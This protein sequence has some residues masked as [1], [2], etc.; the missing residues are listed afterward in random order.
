MLGWEEGRKYQVAGEVRTRLVKTSCDAP[1]VS[2]WIEG[3]QA[4]LATEYL[5]LYI[6]VYRTMLEMKSPPAILAELAKRD[7][8]TADIDSID[9]ALREIE[10]SGA[11]PDGGGPWSHYIERTAQAVRRFVPLLDVQEA[12]SEVA[13]LVPRA[14]LISELWLAELGPRRPDQ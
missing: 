9:T 2:Q 4:G 14:I 12:P 1:L 3:A 13:F 5:S 7:T 6:I 10:R 8:R 11:S